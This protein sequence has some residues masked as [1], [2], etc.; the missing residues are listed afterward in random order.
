MKTITLLAAA[1]LMVNAANA[2]EVINY[3]GAENR[4]TSA[5]S[6]DEPIMFIERGI[7]FYVFPNGEFD[8]NTET[9]VGSDTYYREGRRNTVNRTHGAPGSFTDGGVK[10]EHDAKG[11]VRRVG[12]VF[13]NYDS[14]DRIK[15]IGSVYMTY[16]RNALTQIGNMKIVYNGRGQIV[17]MLGAVK[18]NYGYAYNDTSDHHYTQAPAH[19]EEDY[20]YYRTDGTKAKI[21]KK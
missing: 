1:V 11:R 13:L 15:R 2:T 9:T 10:V 12:N 7:E 8:F 14:A 3:P 17:N 5:F 6:F 16:N 18:G 21:E 20:Y 4:A 19:N